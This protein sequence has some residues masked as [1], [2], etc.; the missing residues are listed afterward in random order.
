MRHSKAIN[1]NKMLKSVLIVI[2]GTGLP[3]KMVTQISLLI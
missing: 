2:G 3:E 1:R